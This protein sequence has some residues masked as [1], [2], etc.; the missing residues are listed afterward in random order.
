MDCSP[1]A[2]AVL[3][4]SGTDYKISHIDYTIGQTKGDKEKYLRVTKLK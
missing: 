4:Y 1:R 2:T 3:K